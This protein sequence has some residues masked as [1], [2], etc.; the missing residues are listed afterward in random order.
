M[1]LDV[2]DNSDRYLSLN[3]GF[4]K[5]FEFLK[6]PDLKELAEGK[7]E[8]DGENVFATIAKTPGRKQD[9]GQ[10]ETHKRY[11]DIQLV[12]G[13]TDNMGWKP[14][15]RCERPAGPYDQEK[16]FQFYLDRPEAW[17]ATKDGTFAIFFPEDGHLPLIADEK[18]H[19]VVVKIAV[20]QK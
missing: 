1:I 12:L 2:L 9:E 8:I 10:L 14:E 17:L 19:K 11:I 4:T 6:R 5:A 18:L 20:D 3:K 15:K 13:G 7:Y 16:D